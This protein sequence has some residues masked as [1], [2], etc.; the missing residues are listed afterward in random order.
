EA[1]LVEIGEIAAAQPAV[2]GPRGG[3]RVVVLVV[4]PLLAIHAQQQLTNATRREF[5]VVL[6]DDPDLHRSDRLADRSDPVPDLLLRHH[7]VGGAGFGHAVG[8]AD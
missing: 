1:V 8:V 4:L 3:G 2:I 7:D 5:S 6:V